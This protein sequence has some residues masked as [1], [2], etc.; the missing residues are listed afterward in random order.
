MSL[1]SGNTAVRAKVNDC[2]V[3]VHENNNSDTYAENGAGRSHYD[4]TEGHVVH[5]IYPGSLVQVWDPRDSGPWVL[6][7]LY[8]AAL[9]DG[10][11]SY[12]GFGCVVMVQEETWFHSV[13]VQPHHLCM[14]SIY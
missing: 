8:L 3:V 7:C 5:T 13:H 1:I 10:Q 12:R 4:N 6:R 9:V 11:L 14:G 2:I